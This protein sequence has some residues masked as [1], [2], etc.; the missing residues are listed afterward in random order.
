MSG[1]EGKEKKKRK[2]H[3]VRCEPHNIEGRALVVNTAYSL[4]NNFLIISEKEKH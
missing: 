4:V 1:R 3:E 2:K